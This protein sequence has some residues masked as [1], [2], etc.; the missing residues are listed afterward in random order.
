MT[1]ARQVFLSI[2]LPAIILLSL[3]ASAAAAGH[4]G[5]SEICHF[6][7][8]KYVEISI[9][10]NALPAHLAHGDVMPD[11]YGNCP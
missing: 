11:I 5:K 3:V 2:A 6:A 10:N 7:S 9:S 4:A 1:H 8:H